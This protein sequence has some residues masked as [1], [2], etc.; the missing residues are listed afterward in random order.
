MRGQGTHPPLFISV[1]QR[2]RHHFFSDKMKT[3]QCSDHF[4][5][6]SFQ[7]QSQYILYRYLFNS[8]MYLNSMVRKQLNFYFVQNSIEMCTKCNR[9]HSQDH[10]TQKQRTKQQSLSSSVTVIHAKNAGRQSLL[11]RPSAVC[12]GRRRFV[13]EA[14]RPSSVASD[15]QKSD[16]CVEFRRTG[17]SPKTLPITTEQGDVFNRSREQRAAAANAASIDFRAGSPVETHILKT[18]THMP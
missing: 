11:F 17:E 13:N 5:K 10:F 9:G 18:L 2:P 4:S 6:M 8:F 1:I 12:D 3:M 15:I 7:H 14:L 16:S